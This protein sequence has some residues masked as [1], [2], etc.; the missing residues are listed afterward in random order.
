[1]MLLVTVGVPPVPLPMAPPENGAGTLLPEKTVLLITVVALP[2]GWLTIAP[3]K[4]RA[5]LPEKV[6]LVTLSV[7]QLKIAPPQAKV[8]VPSKLP[9]PGRQAFNAA[10]VQ[11]ALVPVPTTHAKADEVAPNTAKTSSA[12]SSTSRVRTVARPLAA[13]DRRVPARVLATAAMASVRAAAVRIAN[14]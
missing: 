13:W 4:K 11:L 2:P 5:T 3:P 9:P 14:L 12:R 1:M 7:P 6:L 8:T 10:S